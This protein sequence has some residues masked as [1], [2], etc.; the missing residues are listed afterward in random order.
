MRVGRLLAQHA[1]APEL[2]A[3]VRKI[4]EIAD[5]IKLFKAHTGSFPINVILKTF[6]YERNYL[7]DPSDWLPTVP[8]M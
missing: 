2:P 8:D 1:V 4:R 3:N 7:S 5:E 6:A